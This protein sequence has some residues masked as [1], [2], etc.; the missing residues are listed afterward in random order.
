M[1]DLIIREIARVV[2]ITIIPSNTLNSNGLCFLVDT[3]LT[4]KS[5]SM[6]VL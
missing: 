4:D 6:R 1:I 5:Y 2:N 3:R